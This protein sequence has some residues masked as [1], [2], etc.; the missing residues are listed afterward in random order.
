L[1]VILDADDDPDR[2]GVERDWNAVR[3]QSAPHVAQPSFL[4]E[5]V[6]L[7]IEQAEHGDAR[8]G[9]VGGD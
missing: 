3:L 4:R 5:L 9:V 6:A 8:V 2:L 1:V 7:R